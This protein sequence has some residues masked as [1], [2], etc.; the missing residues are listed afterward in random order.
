MIQEALKIGKQ[1]TVTIP[2]ALREH[3]LLKEGSLII[4]EEREDGILLRPA[5]E[6]PVEQYTPERKAEF[7]LSNAVDEEDYQRAVEAVKAMG[8]NPDDITHL[9]PEDSYVRK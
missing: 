5:T 2:A 3:F 6:M 8:L 4:A 1:G 7:L 9:K